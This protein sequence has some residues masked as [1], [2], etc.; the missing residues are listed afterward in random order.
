MFATSAGLDH[1]GEVRGDGE[2]DAESALALL[3][4]KAYF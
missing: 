1:D 2:S 4:L 3:S